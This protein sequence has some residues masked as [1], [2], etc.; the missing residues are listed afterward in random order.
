[1]KH[2]MRRAVRSALGAGLLTIAAAAPAQAMRVWGE[3]GIAT[4][5][6]GSDPTKGTPVHMKLVLVA[7]GPDAVP[8]TVHDRLAACL[9]RSVVAVVSAREFWESLDVKVKPN[10]T[11]V[12]DLA[13]AGLAVNA[14]SFNSTRAARAKQVG[15]VFDAARTKFM[16]EV[17][18][19]GLPA[20]VAAEARLAI[21]PYICLARGPRA[22]DAGGYLGRRALPKGERFAKVYEWY[23]T[24]GLRRE[25]EYLEIG[26][27]GS[28]T[29]IPAP[30][31]LY[32]FKKQFWPAPRSAEHAQAS[33]ERG[34]VELRKR[35]LQYDY[36]VPRVAA[37]KK[38]TAV[39]LTDVIASPLLSVP[40]LPEAAA[41]SPP[42]KLLQDEVAR[43]RLTECV[44]FKGQQL[45]EK[46][47]A[48]AGYT[49][50]KKDLAA[51]L[52]GG[53][54]MPQ[55]AS[56]GNAAVLMRLAP[57]DGAELLSSQLPRLA[58]QATADVDKYKAAGQACAKLPAADAAV[59]LSK[60]GLNDKDRQSLECAQAV[61]KGKAG[62]GG[63]MQCATAALPDGPARQLAECMAKNGAKDPNAIALCGVST[64]LPPGVRD[65]LP[66]LA[67][68]SKDQVMACLAKSA[69]GDIGNAAAC[70]EKYPNQYNRAGICL[71]EG[72]SASNDVK[73]LV[74]CAAS[75]SG[76]A[77]CA[78][79]KNLHIQGGGDAGK[80]A[81]C[82]IQSG[83]DGMGTL[84]C[85]TEGQ[86][87]AEQQ[88][89]MQCAA[90]S[91]DFL[92][93]AACTGGQLSIREFGKCQGKKFGEEPC[94]G[95]N[96]EI[97]KA[98]AAV[99]IDVGDSTVLGQVANFNLDVL[100]AQVAFAEQ[101]L[102]AAG[103]FVEGLGNAVGNLA[104]G[105]GNAAGGVL[106]AGGN[107]I[108]DLGNALGISF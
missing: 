28:L 60:I 95:K 12:Q 29:A 74:A 68:S 10:T 26:P 105:L 58:G 5:Y 38:D 108:R 43:T 36:I 84:A 8:L 62:A 11:I 98:L 53:N 93:F 52:G 39:R 63:A 37:L 67:K 3:G 9:P 1:M 97:R 33:F 18:K 102:G 92:S 73:Q 82:A 21:V 100:K 91:P 15:E 61:A 34:V 59:C 42:F 48:C 6:V 104:S 78:L 51:C 44:R 50:D 65:N 13:V 70:W 83:G 99:G 89:A 32:A 80:L 27:G 56:T 45:P 19:C 66:C 75:P 47:A 2:V 64:Q 103:Q 94:F 55:L 69:G 87:T 96:N 77:G 40:F 86:L 14:E 4:A 30:Q 79:Q 76:F 57:G 88:I 22:C 81:N 101:A 41:G 46:I 72:S 54:C 23:L 85:M 20:N 49:L 107:A 16:A 71:V 17:R 106:Q 31:E 90:Q 7:T 35:K 25:N 24:A